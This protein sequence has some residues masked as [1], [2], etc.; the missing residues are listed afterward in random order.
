MARSLLEAVDSD[1]R[2]RYAGDALIAHGQLPAG[3]EKGWNVRYTTD[4]TEPVW[5]YV[6]G[7]EYSAQLDYF[8]RCID[9]KRAGDN[10]N[11]FANAIVTDKLMAMMTASPWSAITGGPTR[12]VTRTTSSFRACPTPTSTPTR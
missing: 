9:E 8:V 6:R 11:S 4:L 7:E 1:F 12:R 5:F 2:S 10:V 3:Y